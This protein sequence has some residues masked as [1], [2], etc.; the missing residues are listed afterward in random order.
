MSVRGEGYVNE[1][2]IVVVVEFYGKRLRVAFWRSKYRPADPLLSTE[3]TGE[4]TRGETK[5]SSLGCDRYYCPHS[6]HL[7]KVVK[8]QY[9]VSISIARI[10]CRQ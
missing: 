9:L 5:A 1:V 4:V 7:T 10:L 6:A 8:R 3:D 2:E